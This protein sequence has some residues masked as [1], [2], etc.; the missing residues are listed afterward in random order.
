VDLGWNDLFNTAIKES[1]PMKYVLFIFAPLLLVALFAPGVATTSLLSQSEG[2]SPTNKAAATFAGGCFWCVE[3]DFEKVAGVTEV[4]SGYSGGE[5]VS[6]AY[7]DV[8]SGRTGHVEAAQVIFDPAQQTP[9]RT[10]N[11]S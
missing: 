8:A 4:I 1:N 5:E 11:F 2:E 6:P 3:A 7:Q 9:L 10:S